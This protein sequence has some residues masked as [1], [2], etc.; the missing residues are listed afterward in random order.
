MA[1]D[2]GQLLRLEVE[3]LGVDVEV[4]LK[5]S[6]GTLLVAADRMINDLGPELILAVAP[7][8]GEYEL[9]VQAFPTSHAG[10]YRG[11]ILELR[12][13]VERDRLLAEAYARFTAAAGAAPGELARRSEESLATFR[14]LQEPALVA[15]A[16][17]GVGSAQLKLGDFGRAAEN[18]RQ[19]AE[20][21]A[22]LGER[23]WEALSRAN[24]ATA[25]LTLA[26]A[27][28]AAGEAMAAAELARA[29]GDRRTE[30]KALHCLGQAH[31]NQGDLQAALD[32]YQ[33]ALRLWPAD[34]AERTS[35]VH[36][37]G[38]LHA[39]AFHDQAR[40]LALLAEARSAWHPQQEPERAGTLSQLGQL[41]YEAGRLG[42]A[43]QA[44]EEALALRAGKG[45]CASAVYLARLALVEWGE[46]R[47]EVARARL[48]EANAVVEAERCPKSE[49]TVRLLAAQLEEKRGNSTAARRAFARCTELAQALGDRL[50]EAVCQRGLAGA[51][52]AL[53][54]LPAA[55]DA[56]RRAFEILE[57][58]RP[59]VLRDD[60]RS[61]FF[62]GARPD[63]DTHIQLLLEAGR[64][65]E[66][67]SFTEQARARVLRDLLAEAGAGVRRAVDPGL[68]ERERQLQRRLNALES[69]RLELGEGALETRRRLGREVDLLVAELEEARGDLRR[70]SPAYAALSRPSA[71][72]LAEV[73]R[74]LLT[75]D[76]LLLTLHLGEPASTLWAVDRESFEIVRLPPRGEL[77]ALARQARA[78]Q[79]SL[80]WR[81]ENAE[82]LCALSR[83]LLGP[84]AARLGNRR[85]A[86]VADGALEALAWA[87]LPEPTEGADCASAPPLVAR[88]EI[89]SLP[90]AAALLAQRRLFEHAAANGKAP[91]RGWLA[92]VA[93]PAYDTPRTGH[94]RLPHAAAE[95]AALAALVPEGE[96]RVLTGSEA[97]RQQVEG[98][99]GFPLLHFATHG[100][101]DPAQ[102]LLSAL[103]LAELDVGGQP[104]EGSLPAHA[105]YDLELPAELVVL[106]ACDTAAG[107]EQPGEGL[108]AGL[109]RAFLYAGAARVVVSLWAVEDESSRELM[110]RF[111][112][113]LLQGG[114][115]PAGAL[116]EAQRAL[117]L[118][119]RPPR[120][121]APFVLLGDWRPLASLPPTTHR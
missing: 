73:R 20:T 103:A 98:L 95:A 17:Y 67:W 63:L 69:R 92:V 45:R 107:R 109:P 104:I 81:G 8:A 3:Q 62:G 59:T 24:V 90:S 91:A 76:T 114:L 48:A 97:S 37:L 87:A 66:A 96:A 116:A 40:G 15:E 43:R 61:S 11:Q 118:A 7:V 79:Q 47:E 46:G 52:W 94:R 75:D 33:A 120:Q 39:R 86:I 56:S 21:F 121:W 83:T 9:A 70:S 80:E 64:E 30:A 50:G 53:G 6:D 85:L 29:S 88:H 12:P 119:G 100:L 31:Q 28:P 72:T 19:A 13:A 58:V 18:F 51:E 65:E 16:L 89:V 68:L 110:E 26:E 77:E 14:K 38:V 105:I 108:V 84:I 25:L 4:E 102:P 60:L 54:K 99:S 49:P 117:Y 32:N 1:L 42:E 93:D 106:S 57:E 10:R 113:G 41:A 71:P 101:H 27:E 34:V 35:T 78:W 23:R 22:G 115:G 36:N 111:Y 44:L 112:R 55:L 74:V 2:A 5:G 82:S